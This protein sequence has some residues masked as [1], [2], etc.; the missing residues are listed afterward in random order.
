MPTP[1]QTIHLV[2]SGSSE[3]EFVLPESYAGLEY[4]DVDPEKC[5]KDIVRHYQVH[6]DYLRYGLTDASPEVAQLAIKT[7]D[8]AASDAEATNPTD[9]LAVFQVQLRHA[10]LMNDL[11]ILRPAE[12]SNVFGLKSKTN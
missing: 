1:E 12:K 9:K 5:I 3:E 4:F 6:I 11:K 10:T 7:L 2:S 8:A